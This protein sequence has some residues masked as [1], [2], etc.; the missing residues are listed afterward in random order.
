MGVRLI[1][2]TIDDDFNSIPVADGECIEIVDTMVTGVA[3]PEGWT[4]N[5]AFFAALDGC[6]CGCGVQDPDCLDETL[7]VCDYCDDAGSCSEDECPGSIDPDN[8]AICT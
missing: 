3:V 1:E 5:D 6:D 4:C 2:V 8:N 7:D